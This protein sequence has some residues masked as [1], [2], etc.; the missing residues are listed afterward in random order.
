[1]E[2]NLIIISEYIRYSTIEPQFIHLLE[3][4]G[5]IHVQKIENERFL[6]TEELSQLDRYARLYYDLSINI[7]G[8]DAIHHL[9]EKIDTLQDEMRNLRNRLSLLE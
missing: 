5:L 4:N 3:E 1:M 6:D 7:E 2:T 8:I 9:L